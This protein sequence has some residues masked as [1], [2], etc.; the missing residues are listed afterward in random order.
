MVKVTLYVG[1]VQKCTGG[2]LICVEALQHGAHRWDGQGR[3]AQSR[4]TAWSAWCCMGT[5]GAWGFPLW[6]VSTVCPLS[7]DC[8]WLNLG[9]LPGSCCWAKAC[10]TLKGS[11]TDKK[12]WADGGCCGG[13]IC[14]G[15]CCGGGIC[16]GGCCGGGIC[17][18]G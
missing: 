13:G 12:C 11:G 1:S 7:P 6:D 14:D 3:E 8:L 15:G 10:P 5:P 4:F 9:T 2:V 17:G 16:G 18:G